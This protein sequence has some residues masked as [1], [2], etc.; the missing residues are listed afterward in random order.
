MIGWRSV[1]RE[2]SMEL[3][4]VRY[5]SNKR[6]F[7]KEQT[8]YYRALKYIEEAKKEKGEH[9]LQTTTA[10]PDEKYIRHTIKRL[11]C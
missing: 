10:A 1:H 8:G 9:N 7:M 4:G 2:N 3:F 6:R 11:V 5:V